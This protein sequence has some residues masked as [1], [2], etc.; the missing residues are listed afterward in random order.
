[1]AELAPSLRWE[2]ILEARSQS[3]EE[4]LTGYIARQPWYRTRAAR[5]EGA[6]IEA[7]FPIPEADEAR[8]VLVRV[9]LAGGGSD[10][11]AVPLAI[12]TE[13][14][15]AA[16][17]R[18]RPDAQHLEIDL[19]RSAAGTGSVAIVDALSV[20]RPS[21]ALVGAMLRGGTCESAGLT[22]RFHAVR[23]D[24]ALPKLDA[25]VAL[26]ERLLPAPLPFSTR[27]S[28]VTDRTI[29]AGDHLVAKWIHKADVGENPELE[30]GRYLAAGG[31][32]HT[33]PLAGWIDLQ[34]EGEQAVGGAT[35]AVLTSFVANQGDAWSHLQQ[36]LDGWLGEIVQMGDAA[37][38]K[39]PPN[40]LLTRALFPLPEDVLI[41][42]G[43]YVRSAALLGTRVGEMHKVLSRT[44]IEAFAPAPLDEAGRQAT[45]DEIRRDLARA[46]GA[47]DERAGTLPAEARDALGFVRSKLPSIERRLVNAA[48]APEGGIRTRVHGDL[49][50]G[51][52]LY[53]G[54]DFVIVDF[55][56]DP[57]RP[58][59]ERKAKRSPL[60][61]V[62]GMLRSIHYAAMAGLHARPASAR[63]AL[64]PW[65]ALWY[66]AAM[67]SFLGGWLRAVSESTVLPSSPAVT[68]ALLDLFLLERCVHE[69]AYEI[70]HGRDDF[71]GI[72]LE[73]L[74]DLL[75]TERKPGQ[76]RTS[77]SFTPFAP[78]VDAAKV[79]PAAI[80][81]N[82][83]AMIA[84]KE[85]TATH[86]HRLL[87][88]HVRDDGGVQFAV[89]APNAI[90]VAV[91]GDFNDWS[92][93]AGILPA[94]GDTGVFAG[95][96][97]DARVGQHYMFRFVSPEG[98]P[99]RD[100]ADP[101]AHAAEA[102]PRHASVLTSN[103]YAW[104]DGAWMSERR[105]RGIDR[106]LS[107][108]Q[109]HVGSWRAG[110]TGYREIAAP[111][112]EHVKKLGF[113]HVELL[114]FAEHPQ[115]APAW[116]AGV[117]GFFAPARRHGSLADVKFL[118]D[119]LHQAGI[120]VIFGFATQFARDEHGLACFDGAPAFEPDDPAR[121][122]HPVTG[123]G[124]FDFT[125]PEVRSFL[126]SS[127]T[128][129]IEELHADGLRI[130]GLASVLYRDHRRAP[131]T[132]SPNAEG[133][134]E[135]LEAV[136]FVRRLTGTL[137]LEFPDVLLVADGSAA[138]R[139]VTQSSSAGGLGFDLDW[140]TRFFADAQFVLALDPVERSQQREM[141]TTLSSRIANEELVVALSHADQERG[142]LLQQLGGAPEERLAKLR[143]LLALAWAQRGKKLLFMG[144]ELAPESAWHPGVALDWQLENAPG[145]AGVA[146]MIADLN[147][148]YRER[149]ALCQGEASPATVEDGSGISQVVSSP[150]ASAQDATSPGAESVVAFLRGAPSARDAVLFACNLAGEQHATCRIAVPAGGRYTVIFD[151]NA[152]AYGGAA[153]ES[154]RSF[155]TTTLD[156][157]GQSVLVLTLPPLSAI[158]LAR[159]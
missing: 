15:A 26:D 2:E 52:V 17:R 63:R 67:A 117:T 90:H 46:L 19:G 93:E 36:S 152:A 6:R 101:F 98:G 99:P 27:R 141:L 146:R 38:P 33:A 50:L 132:W 121:S 23:R 54:E 110:Q 5:I 4:A 126:L 69:L 128:F 48:R 55:Q 42:V 100:K 81:P 158:Y 70:E 157:S 8:V 47:L 138:F 143:V 80:A 77:R 107:V 125:R 3:V 156:G 140:D 37:P 28:T 155:E 62:A 135:S 40:D 71:V 29:A 25:P 68:R 134:R 114:P 145:R 105:E 72:P 120:G 20:P 41:A 116:V 130:D 95:V 57:A 109:V 94:L 39:L 112:A 14:E 86:A 127:A 123:T 91:V 18:Q 149:A 1:M 122:V 21:R 60:V 87:G 103:D 35:I 43:D 9:A 32:R 13:S 30:M 11:Y 66:R 133:G 51:Q 108:Y 85:G 10:T 154:A 78:S 76:M 34:R 96:V 139:G 119:T 24:E 22:L 113:T 16:V 56:G 82:A 53:T 148:L 124:L 58:L 49:H 7:A 89:W 106:P 97:R 129:W 159:T 104:G 137:E 45:T 83:P 131:G 115:N 59:A 79:E 12:V 102:A 147:R 151:S 75:E 44:H 73:G 144:N 142:S 118:V 136:S 31:Y 111:L 88:G 153:P 92:T 64:A 65:V 74:K 150:G 61:D 84:F